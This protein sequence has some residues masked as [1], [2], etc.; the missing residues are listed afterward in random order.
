M[1][2][3]HANYFSMNLCEVCEHF[4]VYV[5]VVFYITGIIRHHTNWDLT[6]WPIELQSDKTH[7]VAKI[8][9]LPFLHMLLKGYF[10]LK[11]KLCYYLFTLMSFQTSMAIFPL[12]NIKK[13]LYIF[14][15]PYN[16]SM[17][18]SVV[19]VIELSIYTQKLCSTEERECCRFGTIW[20]WVSDDRIYIFR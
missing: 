3:I 8:C 2:Q 19:L 9:H 11:F 7:C 10:T 15:C 16:K 1:S 18:F 17:G 4:K 20:W 13:N 6:Q 12:W 5:C 14:L